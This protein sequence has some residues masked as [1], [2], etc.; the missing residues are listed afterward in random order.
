MTVET[1]Q[2]KKKILDWGAD[3]VGIASLDSLEW[4]YNSALVE[5]YPY[6]VSLAVRLSDEIIQ[7]IEVDNPTPL[8][9]FH[10]GI[11]NSFLDSLA[12]RITNYLQKLGYKAL[13]IPSSQIIDED[14]LLGELSHR[15]VAEKA[16]LGW[17]GKSQLLVTPQFGPRVRLVTI[18]TNCPFSQVDKPIENGCGNC[19]ACEKACPVGAIKQEVS[20]AE[21]S[22]RDKGFYVERCDD[23]LW[24]MSTNPQIN[25]RICGMCIKACPKGK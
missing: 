11:V 12:L 14:N 8:Y 23:Y 19:R 9:A 13:P 24:E 20:L 2:F 25:D 15:T 18:L 7:G 3:L 10:Y 5:R 21:A 6:G 1:E 4:S 17:R 16:G 22:S